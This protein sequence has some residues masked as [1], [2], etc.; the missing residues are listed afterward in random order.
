METLFI[1]ST[2]AEAVKLFAN[3]Y[4]AMRVCFFN[5]LDSYALANKLDSKSIID[6]ICLDE[7]IGIGY[8]NPSFGYG[9]YCLPKDTKQLL[10]NYNSVP[11][12]IIEAIVT[13]NDTRKEYLSNVIIK[14]KPKTVGVY[15]LIM[16]EGSDNFR[17]SAIQ[18]II[19]RLNENN[20]EVIIY[21]PIYKSQKFNTFEVIQS[22]KEFKTRSDIII[23]NRMSKELET[24]KDKIFTRDI[25]G[26]N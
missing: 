16:K 9:G 12:K 10:A 22:L 6:G 11:Q 15:R 21:E 26:N 13:S 18:G 25:F 24:V 5:E 2:E 23:S 1:S 4:L 14:S 20:I 3:S 7:R 8:N 17:D 19:H